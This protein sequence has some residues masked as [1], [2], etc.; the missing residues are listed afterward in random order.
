MEQQ[1]AKT[2]DTSPADPPQSASA[3]GDNDTHGELPPKGVL[4]NTSQPDQRAALPQEAAATTQPENDPDIKDPTHEKDSTSH[5]GDQSQQD[6]VTAKPLVASLTTS[7]PRETSSTVQ[8]QEDDP[9]VR[10]PPNDEG[11]KPGSEGQSPVHSVAEESLA[12]ISNTS[13]SR[14]AGD[15]T[16]RDEHVFDPQSLEAP[17]LKAVAGK[18]LP[19]I[20]QAAASEEATATEQTNG[21]QPKPESKISPTDVKHEDVR[22]DT[23]PVV[24]AA[25]T[26]LNETKPTFLPLVPSEATVSRTVVP[27]AV[28]KATSIADDTDPTKTPNVSRTVDTTAFSLVN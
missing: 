27:P 15:A 18:P 9:N 25:D 1:S 23:A 26:A 11:D 6:S 3:V 28:S 16:Q 21:V 20:P 5:L 24:N 4:S 10:D 12:G 13:V 17:P 22:R 7:L 8:P 2:S 19:Q 14:G